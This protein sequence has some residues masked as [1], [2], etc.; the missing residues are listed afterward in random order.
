MG[1][2]MA[3]T[4]SG[5]G[6]LGL[7]II[8]AR[9]AEH[10][11][12]AGFPTCTWNRTSPKTGFPSDWRASPAEVAREC[13]ILQLFVSDA[14]AVLGVIESAAP[15]LTPGH[16]VICCATIGRD[17]TLDAEAVVRRSGARFL[18]AP[19]TG[20]KGAAE[21]RQLVYYVGGEDQDVARAMPVLQAS[22]RKVLKVGR[23]GDAAVLKVVTNLIAA[24]SVQVLGEALALVEGA[25]L[26]PAVFEAALAENACRSGTMDLKLPK[27]IT[28]DYEP[29][30]SMKHMSKDVEF[31]RGMARAFGV[32]MAAGSA[33][34]DRMLEA[35]SL[36]LGDLDFAAIY[37][38]LGRRS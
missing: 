3:I 18:D 22:G 23:A 32:E 2:D 19:F 38:G 25:G 20:S 29:H 9:V 10:L 1:C 6:V 7:G 13:G 30:F 35:L 31:A 14:K 26:D 4:A 28:G 37:K 8:G 5:V 34:G 36:G 33:V 17:A 15:E 24:V 21:R 11:R 16:L 12:G 27:M